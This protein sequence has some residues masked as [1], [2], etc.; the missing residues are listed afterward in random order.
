MIPQK[1][2]DKTLGDY[3]VTKNAYVVAKRTGL[4]VSKTYQILRDHG[5]VR[6][7]LTLNYER[8]RKLPPRAQLLSEYEA[9]ASCSEIAERY[10]CEPSTTQQ[11]LKK[12]G[13]KMRPR[14]NHGKALTEKEAREMATH[15]AELKSQQAV[16]ALMNTN[17][18]RVS[19]ALRMLGVESGR[20]FMR[21]EGHPSWKGG[22][23]PAPGGYIGVFVAINDPLRCMADT[24]GRCMEHRLVM[25]RALGRPLSKDETVHHINGDRTDNRPNNLQLRFGKH[26]KGITMTCANCGSHHITYT[27]LD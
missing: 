20:P 26:G 7:G 23:G 15:Y 5:V 3:A 12:A 1:L 16:A 8:I 27:K 10:G 13:A 24:S 25:A 9:G 11:A 18:V 19:K 4:S 17:Q 21:G 14:G 6:E 22:R 2:I